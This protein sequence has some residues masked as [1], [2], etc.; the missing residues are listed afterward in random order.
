MLC[1]GCELSYLRVIIAA[2]IAVWLCHTAHPETQ[3]DFDSR[4][5]CTDRE[6]FLFKPVPNW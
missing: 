4:I 1:I 5:C 2:V 6:K 3:S